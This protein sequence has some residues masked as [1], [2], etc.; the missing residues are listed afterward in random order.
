MLVWHAF[1]ELLENQS[2]TYMPEI[3]RLPHKRPLVSKGPFPSGKVEEKL[4][5]HFCHIDNAIINL[6]DS[7]RLCLIAVHQKKENIC[8]FSFSLGVMGLFINSNILVEATKDGSR[9]VLL[10]TRVYLSE[11]LANMCKLLNGK[12]TYQLLVDMHRVHERILRRKE[13]QH[14]M[15]DSA[16]L[17]PSPP[18]HTHP[19]PPHWAIC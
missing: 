18:P 19:P 6:R 2:K 12:A 1:F 10:S 13:W 9:V 4:S 8:G 15:Y 16:A 3:H 7:L 5:P 11:A 14:T 17:H